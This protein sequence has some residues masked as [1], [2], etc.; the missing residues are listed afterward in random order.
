MLIPVMALRTG[1]LY[2]FCNSSPSSTGLKSDIQ[3]TRKGLA[4]R[5]TNSSK[6]KNTV[7][8]LGFGPLS[9]Y[10]FSWSGVESASFQ[11]MRHTF[12]VRALESNFD[13][14]ALSKIMGHASPSVTYN[15]YAK[16]VDGDGLVRRSMENLAAA[17][18]R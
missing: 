9:S 13:V 7:L 18:R 3:V 12:A 8:F 2:G 15:R 1:T 14:A 6:L 16:F 4:R 11:T 17:M 10:C 5:S